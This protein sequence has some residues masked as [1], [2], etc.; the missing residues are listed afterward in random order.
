[1]GKVVV[2]IQSNYIPWKGYFDLIRRADDFVIYDQV[3]YTKNDWRNRNRIKTANGL[4]WLT[5]PV[6]H[7]HLD[8]KIIDTQ[9]AESS[10]RTKHWKTLQQ[11]YAKTPFF[12]KYADELE[13]LYLTDAET[14][15]SKINLK[16][17]DAIAKWL[18]IAARIHPPETYELTSED[19]T[20]RL[21]D[22]CSRL[23]ASTYLS[24]PSARDY[25]NVGEFE[26][27]GIAVQWM[28]YDDYPVYAQPHGAFHHHVSIL[29]LLF[30]TGSRAV[31][32]LRND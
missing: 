32:Y 13:Q 2:I 16:F 17:I 3:Q 18:G 6:R 1:M 28:K 25:L 15:L 14:N 29:D 12:S 24:G 22:I 21:V 10:W 30:S 9:V 20:K 4:V 7:T 23:G 5:I 31:Q 8:Q 11:A 19:R 27:A 26:R